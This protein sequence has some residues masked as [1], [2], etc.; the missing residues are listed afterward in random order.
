MKR[1]LYA[2]L[3]AAIAMSATSAQADKPSKADGLKRVQQ[4]MVKPP[5]LPKHRQQA[6][7]GPKIVEVELV[8]REREMVI[9]QIGTTLQALTFMGSV[10][11]PII[12]VHEGDYVELTIVN[13]KGEIKGV[14]SVEGWE[15]TSTN[16]MSHNIDL[17][18][19]TGALG[20]AGMTLVMPG[21]QATI[22]FK[23]TKVGVFV[24]HCAPGGPM[25]PYHV[26]Q[27]MNG[28]IMVLPRDGLKDGNGRS[29]KYDRAYYIGEQD[30]YVPKGA[31]GKY[32]TFMSPAAAMPETLEVMKTNEPSHVVFNGSVGALTGE[33]SLTAK[34]GESVLFIHSQANR[35]TRPHLIGGHGDYVWQSGSFDDAPQTDLE[36][37][38]IAGGSAGA[39]LYTF[40]QPGLYVY[41][42]HNL[43]D[44]GLKGAAAHVKVEGE[45]DND[46]LEQISK[47]G[48]IQ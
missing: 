42:N 28:A 31:D 14:D 19:V 36:T 30:F 47:P 7:G 38:F 35:D 44:A 27:G 2:V 4:K 12:V 24:Y 16:I 37:W 3:A 43:I 32:K 17:H 1:L 23:A 41:L 9:D 8:V 25:I 34:V 48:P 6:K 20:G 46:L 22:R 29:L 5:M 26:V 15:G 11:A 10:P 21:E 40:R 13:P 45:W 39:A 18:A 33:N